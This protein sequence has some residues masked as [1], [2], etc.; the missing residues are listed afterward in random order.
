MSWKEQEKEW[1][2]KSTTLPKKKKRKSIGYGYDDYDDLDYTPRKRYTHYEWNP[3][4]WWNYGTSGGFNDDDNSNLYVKD[5]VTYLTPTTQE[6]KTKAG[7][8]LKASVDTIKELTRVCYL[9]MIDDKDYFDEKFSDVDALD[10]HQKANVEAKRALY[11]GIYDN[12]IP[13]YTP[14]EQ[15]I[16]IFQRIQGG[17]EKAKAGDIDNQSPDI[18]LS[19]DRAVYADPLLNEQ[20]DLN[21]L[22][23]QMKMEVLNKIS[24]IG[25]LGTQFKVEKEISEKIVANSDEY[26]KKIMRDYTQVHQIELYQRMLPNFKV[27]FLTKDLTV[28]VPV[29]RSEK[30]Q[31][32]I[33][34]LD[35]SGSMC[36]TSKQLWV[37][38]MLIDRFRYVMKG[39]AEVFFSYF[40]YRTSELQFIHVKDREDV[41]NFW[42]T[43]SNSPSGGTTDIGGI[44]DY[45]SKEVAKGHLHNLKNV[46]L[47]EEKPEI[48]IIND[49]QDRVG[50]DEFPYKVNAVSLMDFSDELKDLCIATGGKQVKIKYDS[51]V[52]CYSSEGKQVLSK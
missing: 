14:L 44:V 38:A 9:K 27:K 6:I 2:P 16:V 29:E 18:D 4:S 17:A 48:L 36:D 11:D 1:Y 43:F 10:D 40:V 5:P 37:N 45:V 28:N 51:S 23:K 33:I 20:L 50:H 24:L 8:W 46:N 35:Y 12:Y 41:L 31:K 19:F 7:I 47:Q 52:T 3:N 22:S 49:G 30:K 34:L 13:G 21:P 39:E 25:D 15:A 26:A 42:Q 32:I